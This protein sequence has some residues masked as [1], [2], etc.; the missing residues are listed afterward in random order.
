VPGNV[1]YLLVTL[2]Q[3]YS[4]VVLARVLLS[5]FPNADRNN[6]I[7]KFL[8]QITEPVLDPVR[9]AMPNLG[10]VD[11]SPIVVFIGL[12]ILRSV[13]LSMAGGL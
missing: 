3:V 8:Y 6:P 2:I 10:M 11:I 12:H 9:R 7:V 13:L 1:V 5:W 4:Y